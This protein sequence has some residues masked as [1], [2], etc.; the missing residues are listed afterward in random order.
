MP[1]QREIQWEIMGTH[2]ARLIRSI[3][4]RVDLRNRPLL[5][6][7]HMVPSDTTEQRMQLIR[8]QGSKVNAGTIVTHLY[9]HATQ[10]L[11]AYGGPE[12][13][14]PAQH[15][16]QTS[17]PPSIGNYGHSRCLSDPLEPLKGGFTKSPSADQCPCGTERCNSSDHKGTIVTH[18]YVHVQ[19]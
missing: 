15:K 19:A 11:C 9:A 3:L 18:I 17:S 6:N 10:T 13:E 12:S 1:A 5:T 16:I 4:S 2:D 14:M 7:D 8:P